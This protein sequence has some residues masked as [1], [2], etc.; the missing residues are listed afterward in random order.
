MTSEEMLLQLATA[1]ARA[2]AA[3]R[4]WSREALRPGTCEFQLRSFAIHVEWLKQ[5][6]LQQEGVNLAKRWT[7]L[8]H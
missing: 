6:C 3:G 2:F 4:F 7:R 8:G 5:E 1:F